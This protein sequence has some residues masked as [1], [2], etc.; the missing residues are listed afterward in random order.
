MRWMDFVADHHADEYGSQ[1]SNF[2]D[3]PG[4]L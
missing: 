1:L 4:I 2:I 3:M